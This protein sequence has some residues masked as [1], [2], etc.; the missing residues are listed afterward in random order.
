ML[1]FF[2]HYELPIIL[3]QARIQHLV[4]NRNN[5]HQNGNINPQH[6]D[7][8]DLL[9]DLV[10]LD[11]PLPGD[12]QLAADDDLVNQ[13]N[14][15]M[16]VINGL[17][18]HETDLHGV[19]GHDPMNEVHEDIGQEVEGR[20]S[21]DSNLSNGHIPGVENDSS[22]VSHDSPLTNHV[23][24]SGSH[25][26]PL[27]NHVTRN[28]SHDSSLTNHVIH[29]YSSA[30]NIVNNL[31][32]QNLGSDSETHHLTRESDTRETDAL[33]DL[34]RPPDLSL[35]SLSQVDSYELYGDQ[36]VTGDQSEVQSGSCDMGNQSEVQSGSCDTGN[37]SDLQLRSS[38]S[39]S[40]LSSQNSRSHDLGDRSHDLG[41]RS[42]DLSDSLVNN[43]LFDSSS[44][45]ENLNCAA[46]VKPSTDSQLA[47]EENKL[48]DNG[49]NPSQNIC[50]SLKP[51]DASCDVSCDSA[52]SINRTE[53]SNVGEH[54]LSV[55]ET[56]HSS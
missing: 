10:D 33:F 53:A 48:V 51:C 41:D 39:E 45:G 34:G 40:R 43:F 31:N 52:V 36:S 42:H 21:D 54:S 35:S 8:E 16:E 23:T 49:T 55:T 30:H 24:T 2:H 5:R 38:D 37:Q 28:E 9:H 47:G 17:R 19:R 29:A 26:N 12:E 14:E 32:V 46:D 18:G 11:L 50:D 4:N 27:T 22:V 3:Q 1:Y 6:R 7:E 20:S 56:K 25:G 44:S 13:N 15:N